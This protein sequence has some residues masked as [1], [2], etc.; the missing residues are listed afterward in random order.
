MRP[1]IFLFLF[2]LSA[3]ANAA[4]VFID[5]ETYADGSLLTAPTLINETNALTT[6]YSSL[7][8]TWDG[9]GAIVND[10]SVPGSTPSAPNVLVYNADATFSNGDS[11]RIY[12]SM[13]F[14]IGQATVSFEVNGSAGGFYGEGIFTA[15]AYDS[16]EQIVDVQ[17]IYLDTEYQTT[18]LSG[19]DIMR[20]D[21]SGSFN[22]GSFARAM[23]IDDI[24]FSTVPVPAAVWL[25]GS[26]LG[27]LGWM[28]RRKTV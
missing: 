11:S 27:G 12:D 9:G 1:I 4:T 2:S 18:F 26:A 15:T 19:I 13:F 20:V 22:E 24:Q 6:T 23:A 14:S 8:V 25:F 5:F 17:T 10:S 21:Y 3:I 16:L 7:G 28:R